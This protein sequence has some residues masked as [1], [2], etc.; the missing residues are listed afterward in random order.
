MIPIPLL[1]LG[2][3]S[4]SDKSKKIKVLESIR[5]VAIDSSASTSWNNG[6]ELLKKFI[7]SL[8]IQMVR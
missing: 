1:R 6:D 8:A 7:G 4:P 2:I 3:P 5:V